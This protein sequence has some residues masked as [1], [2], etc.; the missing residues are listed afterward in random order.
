MLKNWGN[1]ASK[2]IMHTRNQFINL[3]IFICI[4]FTWSINTINASQTNIEDDQDV[5]YFNTTAYLDTEKNAWNIPIHGWIFE[6]DTDSVWRKTVVNL[7]LSKL[8]VQA[9]SV[10]NQLFRKRAMYFLVDNKRAKKIGISIKDIAFIANPSQPNGHFLGE[11]QL[12]SDKITVTEKNSWI[13]FQSH[14]ETNKRLFEGKVQLVEPEGLSVISDI[15]D[16]IKISE[17][18]DKK[19]LIE[20][21]FLN[22]FKPVP[23]MA[24]L[25]SRLA[26]E[27][28]VFHYVSCSPWQLYPSLIEFIRRQ[29]F[30]EGSFAMKYF[31][32]KDHTFY[33]IFKKP[34]E[35]KMQAIESIINIYP[36]KKY[37]LIGDSGESD[38]QIYAEI[39]E[40]HPA[41]ITHIYIRKVTSDIQPIEGAFTKLDKK[42]WTI[43]SDP[44]EIKSI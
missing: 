20:N 39:A 9:S 36:K 41:S 13:S 44:K 33:N 7:L 11:I 12:A 23:G 24:E 26:K 17:V 35:F 15:D 43:F 42:V 31:R 34:Y 16:T 5:I 2:L 19:K 8:E 1:F 6:P 25:Y 37:I 40:K 38:P 22:E 4:F 29:G 3:F 28:A 21:T 27:G 32:L 14:D 18:T 10:E 30:P